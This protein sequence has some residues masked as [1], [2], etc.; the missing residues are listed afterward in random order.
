M[1][2]TEDVDRIVANPKFQQL[3]RTRSRISW[4]MF[5]TVT[6]FYYLLMGTVAF[7]PE[8]LRAL[9]SPDSVVTIGWPLGAAVIVVSW[10]LTGLYIR[11]ANN[12]LEDLNDAVLKDLKK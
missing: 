6:T 12:D 7:N 9:I 1:S 3:V 10:L 11:K 5:F 2:S 4:G 8:A